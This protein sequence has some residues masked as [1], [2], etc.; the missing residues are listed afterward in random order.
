M[1]ALTLGS[2][3]VPHTNCPYMYIT[4]WYSIDIPVVREIQ[5]VEVEVW[6]ETLHLLQHNHIPLTKKSKRRHMYV[7]YRTI[8]ELCLL[9]KKRQAYMLSKSLTE[10]EIATCILSANASACWLIHKVNG[11]TLHAC[12]PLY[13]CLPNRATAN[14]LVSWAL[15]KS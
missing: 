5:M 1:Q 15:Y 2:E 8:R 9:E 6:R 4:H 13:C 12:S 7:C 11:S 10:M 3:A 14:S